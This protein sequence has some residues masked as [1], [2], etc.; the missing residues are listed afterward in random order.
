MTTFDEEQVKTSGKMSDL[1][2]EYVSQFIARDFY[3]AYEKANQTGHEEFV[4]LEIDNKM[5]KKIAKAIRK[6]TGKK[7]QN[8]QIWRF[9]IKFIIALICVSCVAFTVM[10]LLFYDPL[11]NELFSILSSLSDRLREPF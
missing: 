4:P 3:E 7:G 2:M 11:R 5:Y 1:V 9:I 10:A 6:N 8:T